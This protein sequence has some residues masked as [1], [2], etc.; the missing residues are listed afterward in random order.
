VPHRLDLRE[1]F[2]CRNP[3]CHEW[4]YIERP[5]GYPGQVCRSGAQYVFARTTLVDHGHGGLV[6]CKR[7]G[8]AHRRA[9]GYDHRS[10]LQ[11][12]IDQGYDPE[13]YR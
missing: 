6:T 10:E 7:C 5:R 8:T 9:A 4:R 3:S 12:A 13:D 11:A 2:A 1:Y